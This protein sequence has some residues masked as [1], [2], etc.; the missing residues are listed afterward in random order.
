MLLVSNMQSKSVFL[1]AE[2]KLWPLLDNIFC[3]ILIH[4]QGIQS[5]KR[6]HGTD[7][8]NHLQKKACQKNPNPGLRTMVFYVQTFSSLPYE[9]IHPAMFTPFMN[10]SSAS[11]IISSSS[12]CSHSSI[13]EAS[14][15]KT[16]YI[17]SP[18]SSS[19]GFSQ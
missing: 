7:C 1:L 11:L 18:Y 9:G 16:L 5:Q 19:H 15:F 8:V 12:I 4:L 14:S 17:F 3:S 2:S 6:I 10:P 13:M